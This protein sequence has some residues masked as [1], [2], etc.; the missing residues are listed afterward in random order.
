MFSEKIEKCF[1]NGWVV[2]TKTTDWFEETTDCLFWYHNRKTV[3]CFDWALNVLTDC[4]PVLN[5]LTNL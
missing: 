1:S 4:A 3:L 2:K 5:D